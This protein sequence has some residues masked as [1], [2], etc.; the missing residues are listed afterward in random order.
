MIGDSENSTL[1]NIKDK[2]QV[3]LNRSFKERY[4]QKID[5]Y[6]NRW[7]FA[8]PC[9][10]DSSTDIRKKRGNLFLDSLSYHCYNCGEHMGINSFLNRFDESLS[11]EDKIAVHEIQQN[12]KKFERRTSQQQ[13]SMSM[14]ILERVAIPKSILFKSLGVV[15]P[16]KNEFASDYLKSRMIDIKL[17]KYFAYKPNTKELYIL[18][19][20]P[21]DRVIGYQIRQLDP[22]SKKARYITKSLTKMYDDIFKRDIS[23]IV[24]KLLL[25]EE[26]GEKYINEEDGIENIVFNLDKLS[27][28]FNIMNINLSQTITV[29][30]GPID[31]LAISNSIALQGASKKLNGFFDEVENVRYIFDNDMTGKEMSIKKL[32][33]HKNVFLW[34]MYLKKIHSDIKIKDINDLQK[35]NMLNMELIDKC[36]SDDELDVIMI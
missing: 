5:F 24:E 3:I 14:S 36:F 6:S 4:R 29:M 32:K 9:C 13:S 2:I 19:I 20:T 30:E 33:D 31:S 25:K 18:N 8:C 28:M 17:W 23:G 35:N 27:G 1:E 22:N 7:N 16:Y 34:T 10:G 26:L 12:S 11:N 21:S 15:T